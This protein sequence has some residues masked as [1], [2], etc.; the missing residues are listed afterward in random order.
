[1]FI[2]SPLSFHAGTAGDRL[3][4][5]YCLPTRLTGA[6]CHDFLRNFLPELMQDV[7]LQI[8]MCLWFMPVGAAPHFLLEFQEFLNSVF[9]AQWMEQSGPIA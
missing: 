2:V 8:R 1:M 9:L 5:P 7:D 3:V 6:L 4:G